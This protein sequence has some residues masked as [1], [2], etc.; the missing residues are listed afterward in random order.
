[1]LGAIEP[2]ALCGS[3]AGRVL[4]HIIPKFVYRH[5][6]VRAPNGYLRS[7]ANPNRRV[8]DGVKEYLLCV[9]CEGV[10]SKWEREFSKIFKSH[11]EN[12]GQNLVYTK[13]DAL[14]ALS[15]LWRSL[16]HARLHPEVNHP[17]FGSDYSRTD[18]AFETWR[19][20]LLGATEHPGKYRIMWVFLDYVQK[21]HVLGKNVN[22]Y[23]F[24][25]SDTNVYATKSESFAYAHIPGIIMIGA[26]EGIDRR[27]FRDFDVS[28]AGGRYFSNENKRAPEMFF[29]IIREQTKA[30][31]DANQQISEVQMKKIGDAALANPGHL[32]GSLMVR[33]HIHDEG[34]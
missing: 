15:I 7:N 34:L 27:E 25:A 13:A 33:T 2:C 22:R 1:M 12:P 9:G 20:V 17:E 10:F 16:A 18:A 19:K 14:C 5:A 21:G 32:I 23:L 24:H 3:S 26:L 30:M 6:S 4:S 11:N 31:L 8:Q 28:F 29:Q